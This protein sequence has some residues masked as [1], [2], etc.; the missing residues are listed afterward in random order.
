MSEK[1]LTRAA[2]AAVVTLVMASC[3]GKDAKIISE[4]EPGGEENLAE[5]ADGPDAKVRKRLAELPDDFTFAIVSD[6]HLQTDPEH[7][8]NQKFKLSIEKI[9]EI[10]PDFVVLLGDLTDE[11]HKGNEVARAQYLDFSLLAADLKPVL[12]PVV[13]NH[14]AGE[15]STGPDDP[16]RPLFLEMEARLETFSGT[17]YSFD[18]G[19]W[20]F[21]VLDTGWDAAMSEEQL[22]WLEGDLARHSAV[23]TICFMHINI[24]P[25][26]EQWL[27][28]EKNTVFARAADRERLLG[29]LKAGSVKWMFTGHTHPTWKRSQKQRIRVG[30]I[31]FVHVPALSRALVGGGH[32]GSGF[33]LVHVKGDQVNSTEFVSMEDLS[34]ERLPEPAPETYQR[35]SSITTVEVPEGNPVLDLKP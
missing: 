4:C 34:G 24:T 28:E 26:G 35:F 23:P 33:L 9:N 10:N 14:D 21:V 30:D 22:E 6:V 16:S 12:V 18:S 3:A 20:H 2:L 11:G 32:I 5:Q 1:L 8:W 7:A 13:G 17:Y 25:V 15:V 31:R 19:K 29:I 27:D